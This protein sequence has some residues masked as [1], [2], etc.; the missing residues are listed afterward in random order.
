MPRHSPTVSVLPQ[1]QHRPFPPLF[2]LFFIP[3]NVNSQ[4]AGTMF[5]AGR[6]YI[7]FDYI[8]LPHR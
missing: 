2:N 6:E 3:N 8:Y 1:L 4:A 5:T 7:H